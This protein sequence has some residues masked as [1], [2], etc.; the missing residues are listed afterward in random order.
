METS[1]TVYQ[2]TIA[3]ARHLLA[4]A[5]LRGDT[6]AGAASLE[7]VCAGGHVFEAR[8]G[9]GRPVMAYVLS[10]QDHAAAR[11][12]WVRAAGGHLPGVDLT[13]AMLPAIERQ[14][15]THG[16]GQVAI[17]TRRGG[18]IKKLKAQGYKI[19]GVTLRKAI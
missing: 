1:L 17:T 18:L 5:A 14:A 16:A 11:V 15:R 4:R 3:D 10:L 19:T 9:A 8:D 2:S 6:T 13:A 12:C 7:D